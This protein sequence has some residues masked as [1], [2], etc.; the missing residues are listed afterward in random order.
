MKQFL[1]GSLAALLLIAS[2]RAVLRADDS[3]SGTWSLISEAGQVQLELSW[4]NGRSSNQSTLRPVDANA[5]GIANE[6]ASNGGRVR[7]GL[8]REAGDYSL[9]GWVAGGKGGGTYTFTPNAAFFDD[10]RSRGYKIAGPENELAAADLDVTREYVSELEHTGVSLD[11]E[12]LIAFR[13]LGIDAAYIKAMASVGFTHLSPDQ[14]E[15]MKALHIDRTYVE[16]IRAEGVT[17]V[18]EQSVVELKALHVDASYMQELA[19][20]GYPHLSARDYVQLK[21]LHIDG[22]YVKSLAHHGLTHLTVGQL[23][24]YKA[25]GI[26]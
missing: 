6:L 3:V 5:L 22:E 15:S 7:F 18:N 4:S 25:L 19:A 17:D 20:A 8:H 16:G 1:F 11:F 10:M 23:V 21:A 14:L 26:R 24:N 2:T 13:A 9:E 12:Q